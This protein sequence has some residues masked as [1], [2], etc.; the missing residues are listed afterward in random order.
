[1]FMAE[2]T[3]LS[4]TSSQI[5]CSS[6]LPVEWVLFEGRLIWDISQEGLDND[7]DSRNINVKEF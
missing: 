1:M 4:H 7:E 2:N 5:F 6:I 3:D